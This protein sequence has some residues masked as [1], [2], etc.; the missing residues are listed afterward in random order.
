MPT[1]TNIGHSGFAVEAESFMLIFDYYQGALPPLPENKKLYVFV[2]HRHPDHFNPDIFSLCSSHRDVH[3]F[4]SDDIYERRVREHVSE[5]YTMVHPGDD[6]Y[7]TTRFRIKVL[8]STDCGVAFLVCVNGR[9]FFHAGDL[10]LWLWDGMTEAE[11]YAMTKKFEE[12]TA[13]LKNFVIDTAFLP[14]DTRQGIY[15]FL[16][17][18]YYMKHFKILHAIPMHFFGSPKISRDLIESPV[19]LKYRNKIIPLDPGCTTEIK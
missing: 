19:S 9:N 15:S 4:I 8:P 18:D 14:L 6:I 11:T 5:N 12:C 7:L 3:Y 16:G 2:S 17:F 1:I 13:G 10:N